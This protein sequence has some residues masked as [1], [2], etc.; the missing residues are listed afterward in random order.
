MIIPPY[1]FQTHSVTLAIFCHLIK[2][3]PL[4]FRHEKYIVNRIRMHVKRFDK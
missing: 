1:V 4:T 2:L 3:H